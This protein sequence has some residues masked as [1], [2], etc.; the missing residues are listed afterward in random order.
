MNYRNLKGIYDGWKRCSRL[1]KRPTLADSTNLART[2]ARRRC[3]APATPARLRRTVGFV[4][5]S[6]RF[7]PCAVLALREALCLSRSLSGR[8]SPSVSSPRF[9]WSALLPAEVRSSVCMPQPRAH[10]V[11]RFAELVLQVLLRSTRWLRR[12]CR[13]RATA[14]AARGQRAALRA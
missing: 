9:I 3:P 5:P 2:F 11:F 10:T 8:C 7:A 14:S 1:Q 6:F 4:N 12:W 13:A